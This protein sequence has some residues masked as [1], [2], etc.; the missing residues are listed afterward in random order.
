MLEGKSPVVYGDGQ[1]SRDFTF[2]ANVV[3]AN[4]LAGTVTGIGG[5]LFNVANGAATSLLTLIDE[6]N[7]LLGTSIAADHEPPRAG[8]VRDSM[9]D[10]SLARRDLGYDPRIEFREGLERS[11]EYY[12]WLVGRRQ[13]QRR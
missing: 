13:Q 2:V 8:D 7:R 5:R 3:Q 1:Q 9:A 10:I 11:I 6:L 12:R 4:L